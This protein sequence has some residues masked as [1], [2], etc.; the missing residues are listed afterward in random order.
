MKVGDFVTV[1]H[2]FIKTLRDDARIFFVGSEGRSIVHICVDE[3]NRLQQKGKLSPAF[4]GFVPDEI[5]VA[6]PIKLEKPTNFSIRAGYCKHCNIL[7]I[8]EESEDACLTK[9]K[10]R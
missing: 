3:I 8:A 1:W 4:T 6:K 2:S 7:W 10:K 5:A 9:L